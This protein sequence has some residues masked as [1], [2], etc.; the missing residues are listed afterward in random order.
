[1]K[2][3]I[4]TFGYIAIC[5]ACF[6]AG[7]GVGG[8]MGTMIG[9]ANYRLILFRIINTIHHLDAKAPNPSLSRYIEELSEQVNTK[10]GKDLDQGIAILD[11]EFTSSR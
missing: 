2:T 10:S 8:N 11:I 5:L 9:N 3:T 4:L 1:M 6:V 7:F